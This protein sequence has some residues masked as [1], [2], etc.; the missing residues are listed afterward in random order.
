MTERP[1]FILIGDV[2]VKPNDIKDYGI[3]KMTEEVLKVYEL[4]I[5]SKGSGFFRTNE[6]TWVHKGKF[7]PFYKFS[8]EQQEA[9]GNPG[10]G[11][12]PFI[13]RQVYCKKGERYTTYQM[14][15]YSDP[16]PQYAPEDGYYEDT[17]GVP[18]TRQDLVERE[19]A[20]LFVNTGDTTHK[21]FEDE[22]DF[23]IYEKC[24][25]LDKLLT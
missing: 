4:V 15:K 19:V 5:E 1:A 2:R 20:Y 9:L 13:P 8:E 17:Y 6:E 22:E 3:K 12:G 10:P 7:I 23:D 16:E 25:E 24:K 18:A 14:S 11:Y 21:F